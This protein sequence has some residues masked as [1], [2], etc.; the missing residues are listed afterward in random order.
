MRHTCSRYVP[1]E[2]RIFAKV[3]EIA[4]AYDVQRIVLFGSRARRTHM[5][6]SDVDLAVY[7]CSKFREFSL[8][9]HEDVDTLLMFDLIHMDQHV[10]AEL[11]AAIAQDGVI[12][13]EKI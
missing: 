3:R 10:S 7:G 5:E 13:Y 9:V 8:A 1:R 6:K 12:I 11:A 4:R 2:E